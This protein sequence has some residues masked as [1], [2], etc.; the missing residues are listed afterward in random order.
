MDPL[1]G[2]VLS[3]TYIHLG[4]RQF[5]RPSNLLADSATLTH[6]AGFPWPE[7]PEP[8]YAM[9]IHHQ[10]AVQ[11][12]QSTPRSESLRTLQQAKRI[13]WPP[14]KRSQ[15]PRALDGEAMGAMDGGAASHPHV[16]QALQGLGPPAPVHCVPRSLRC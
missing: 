8:C 16:L 7:W 5:F 9:Q 14:R 15:G 3:L 4:M 2:S 10:T 11:T 12:A 6:L 1:A 13:Q